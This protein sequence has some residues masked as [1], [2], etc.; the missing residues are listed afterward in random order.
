[1]SYV[2]GSSLHVPDVI[3]FASVYHPNTNRLFI[4]K[5]QSLILQ[6]IFS[7]AGLS[8]CMFG[9]VL[10]ILAVSVFSKNTKVYIAQFRVTTVPCLTFSTL[11]HESGE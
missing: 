4:T 7:Q 2:F 6:A 9:P 11:S 1:M 8:R 5:T 3:C 10:E